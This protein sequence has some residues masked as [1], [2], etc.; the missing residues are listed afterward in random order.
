MYVAE[1]NA[2]N[3]WCIVGIRRYDIERAIADLHRYAEMVGRPLSDFRIRN[4]KGANTHF[5]P[6]G[7][8]NDARGHR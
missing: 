8:P 6:E 3:G 2:E 7:I 5:T 1:I 4:T